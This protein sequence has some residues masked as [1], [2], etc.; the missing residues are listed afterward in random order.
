MT[1]NQQG[2]QILKYKRDKEGLDSSEDPLELDP[3]ISSKQFTALLHGHA[4]RGDLCCHMC[5]SNQV[6]AEEEDEMFKV[7][8]GRVW[9]ATGFRF[10]FVWFQLAA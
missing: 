9:E 6:I 7:I 5:I 4:R 3:A 10:T 8:V 1:R 2:C